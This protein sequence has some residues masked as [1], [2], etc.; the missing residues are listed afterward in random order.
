MKYIVCDLDGTACNEEHR[1]HLGRDCGDWDGYFGCLDLDKPHDDVFWLLNMAMKDQHTDI[2]F[3]TCR[4]EKYR[5]QTEEW[6]AENGLGNYCD[7]IMRAD[8]DKTPSEVLKLQSL[9]KCFGTREDVL[10][11][12]LVVL[13][14][15]DKVVKALRE[16]GLNVW[17]V[18]QG[19]Y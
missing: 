2:L 10:G 12:V 6:L 1:V 11:S 18:R 3:L 15:R 16:Y 7:L 13:E 5:R 17:A 19:K 8:D 14:D 9:E 4:P